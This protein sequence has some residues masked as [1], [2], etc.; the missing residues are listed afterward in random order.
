MADAPDERLENLEAKLAY[1]EQANDELSDVLFAQQKALDDLAARLS[2]LA[3]RI[4]SLED[5]GPGYT[6]ADE[7]PPHY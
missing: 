4:D 2:R 3:G 6:A 5:P 1:L 7:K